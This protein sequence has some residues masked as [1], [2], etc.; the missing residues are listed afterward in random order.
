MKDQEGMA[1]FSRT[2]RPKG[3]DPS[4]GENGVLRYNAV[5]ASRTVF[6]R[7]L[8]RGKLL[9]FVAAS[10]GSELDDYGLA[11]FEADGRLDPSFGTDGLAMH[12]FGEATYYFATILVELHDGSLL[13]AGKLGDGIEE[14]VGLSRLHVDG[15]LDTSFG[16]S[17]KVDL[18]PPVEGH[19]TRL[20]DIAELGDGKI[21]VT[22]EYFDAN[23]EYRSHRFLS[24]LTTSGTLDATFGKS[25]HIVLPHELVPEGSVATGTGHVVVLDRQLVEEGEATF[26]YQ[27]YVRAYNGDASL[28]PA[29]GV[30]GE[31][32]VDRVGHRVDLLHIVERSDGGFYI[33][34]E[35]LPLDQLVPPERFVLS[36]RSDGQP[37]LSFNRGQMLYTASNLPPS[38]LAA[39]SL[40]R[41]I[42]VGTKGLNS[43]FVGRYRRDGSVDNSF[44]DASGWMEYDTG[45]KIGSDMAVTMVNDTRILVSYFQQPY[46]CVV[47]FLSR[48]RE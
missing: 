23:N 2:L 45:D 44:G 27:A 32:K 26:Y 8:P 7:I 29:F 18:I 42:V 14:R 41:L 47:C 17:G 35:S 28:N 40:G 6:K 5:D 15:R 13:I 34:G 33:L 24:R 36:L 31:V 21:L 38:H 12:S 20:R 39:D 25:G 43:A 30:R 37:D 11:M 4:F 22:G 16:T 10:I 48:S 1:A 19:V 9:T 46:A 3:L